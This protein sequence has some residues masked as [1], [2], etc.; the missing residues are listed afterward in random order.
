MASFKETFRKG[1]CLEFWVALNVLLY[2]L[3]LCEIERKPLAD[4][5]D[6]V[7]FGQC[8]C[9]CLP[10]LYSVCG[11]H[12]PKDIQKLIFDCYEKLSAMVMGNE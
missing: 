2:Y 11:Y 4:C 7:R 5:Y 6:M 3:K 10:Q 8:I 1:S 9:K 12:V